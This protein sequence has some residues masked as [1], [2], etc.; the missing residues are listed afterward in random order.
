MSRR[1]R[2]V[3]RWIEDLLRNRRPRR[4]RGAD[5]EKDVLAAAIDLRSAS[6]GAGLPDPH[7]VEGLRRRLA[8]ETQGE[9]APAP[10][11]SRR[12]LL[13]SGGVAA[14]TAAAGVVLGERIA[15]PPTGPT[16]LGPEGATWTAVADVTELS[17]G[18]AKLFDTGSVRGVLVNNAGEISALSAVC[19]HLGCLLQLNTVSRR[20]D[21]PCHRA[22]FSFDGSVAFKEM[23]QSLPPLPKI[24]SRVRDGKIEVLTV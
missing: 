6:A 5:E 2:R 16:N 4:F 21:C 15:G 3:N 13:V 7:F 11:L 17:A 14:A 20:L 9:V 8:Q 24:A 12:S 19:T 10:R 1:T 18:N 22:A 23:L